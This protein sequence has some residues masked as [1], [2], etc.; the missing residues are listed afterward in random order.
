MSDNFTEGEMDSDA[1]PIA[2]ETM[3]A[4]MH[5]SVNRPS[6]GVQEHLT[7][8]YL[9]PTIHS[10]NGDMEV[11][12]P[13]IVQTPLGGMMPGPNAI[14]PAVLGG[15]VGAFPLPEGGVERS[16]FSMGVSDGFPEGSPVPV[17]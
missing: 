9:M 16:E 11:V 12:M 13:S 5:I 15:Q 1:P 3:G 6:A 10:R 8:P 2:S 7:E 14:A 4:R 17:R